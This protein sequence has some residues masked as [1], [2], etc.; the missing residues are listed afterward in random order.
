M[1][2][3]DPCIAPGAS[4]VSRNAREIKAIVEAS[5]SPISNGF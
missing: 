2:V 5:G 1:K 4:L 3:A